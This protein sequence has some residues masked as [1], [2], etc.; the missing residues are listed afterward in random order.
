L[1]LSAADYF[2]APA[3][4]SIRLTQYNGWVK[5]AADGWLTADMGVDIFTVCRNV[6]LD[7]RMPVPV[8]LEFDDSVKITQRVWVDRNGGQ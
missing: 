5:T 3:P 7:F 2:A 4:D 6:P 8:T 1:Q